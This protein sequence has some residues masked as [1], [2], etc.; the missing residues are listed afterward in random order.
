MAQDETDKIMTLAPGGNSAES[1]GENAENPRAFVTGSGFVLQVYGGLLAFS[2]CAIW[3]VSAMTPTS[4][5]T[6]AARWTD[7]LTGPQS[8]AALLTIGLFAGFVGGLALM[9]AGVG[10]Q[11]EKRG[12]AAIATAVSGLLAGVF[13]ALSALLAFSAGRFLMSGAALVVGTLSIAATL[14]SAISHQTLRR[15]PPP[16]DYHLL[17]E[18]ILEDLR[19][20]REERRKEYDF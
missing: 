3:G 12:S 8:A 20:R 18:E 17:T 14:L 15:F 1:P 11:G 10:M 4:T 6:P 13:V 7:H 9:A 2:A 19:R 16:E 5:A